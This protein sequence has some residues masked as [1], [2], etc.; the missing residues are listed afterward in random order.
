MGALTVAGNCLYAGG[1]RLHVLDI[2]DPVNPVIVGEYDTDG[3]ARGVAAVGNSI[4][5][6]AG[7]SILIL[8]QAQRLR[9]EMSGRELFRFSLSGKPGESVRI[10]RSAN[11]G[12]WESWQT[13]TLGETPFELSDPETSEPGV[14]IFRAVEP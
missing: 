12:D 7:A 8:E 2:R 5:V 1:G 14:S 10:Q 9:F 4:Y 11:L 13:V 6:A 3:S